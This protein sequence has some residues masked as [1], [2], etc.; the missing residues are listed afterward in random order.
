MDSSIRAKAERLSISFGT[1]E[2][3][4]VE[5]EKKMVLSRTDRRF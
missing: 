2:V 1:P 3:M 5:I 4:M